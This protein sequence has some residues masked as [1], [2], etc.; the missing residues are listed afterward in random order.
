MYIALTDQNSIFHFA[1]PLLEP[2][3]SDFN[4]SGGKFHFKP[5]RVVLEGSRLDLSNKT[6]KFPGAGRAKAG[7]PAEGLLKTKILNQ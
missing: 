1:R 6:I 7:R 3:S 2:Q 4:N 5:S